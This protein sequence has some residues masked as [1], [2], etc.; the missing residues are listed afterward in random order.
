MLL[1][2]VIIILREI[3]EA[4]LLISL[5]AAVSLRLGLSR[6]WAVYGIVLGMVG[7][8]VYGFEINTIS[9]WFDG[10]GQEVVNAALQVT[11]Y[12]LLATIMLMALR[13]ARDGT[14]MT[15]LPYLMALAV[16]LAVVREGFDILVYLYGFFANGS[17]L[18]AVSMGAFIG[19][20]IGISAGV[21]LYYALV[22]P[23][24]QRMP[25][26][27]FGLLALFA[28]GLL[29][30]AIMLLSQA[31]WLPPQLP[32]WDTSRWLPENSIA[33]QLFYVLIG[34]EATPTA[35]Q[36]VFHLAAVLV[37]LSIAIGIHRW[38][39]LGNEREYS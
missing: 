22:H 7:A 39:S 37:L 4:A 33:G 1:T 32:I 16:A 29:S 36:A 26:I 14:P 23:M 10:F 20:G 35:I 8:I 9:T 27:G 24:V 6:K 13:H 31:D 12:V 15:A 30:Q 19:A 18:F 3:L 2:S 38:E 11:I 34:Y 5:L 25:I 17:Q 21:L 28:A